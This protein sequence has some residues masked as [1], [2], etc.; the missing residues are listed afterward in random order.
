MA[1]IWCSTS[2][3]RAWNSH[4]INFSLSHRSL[5]RRSPAPSTAGTPR[6]DDGVLDMGGQCPSSD[7]CWFLKPHKLILISTTRSNEL[8]EFQTKVSR[9]PRLVRTDMRVCGYIYI[10]IFIYLSVLMC[11]CLWWDKVRCQVKRD[12][13][14]WCIYTVFTQ[15]ID[16]YTHVNTHI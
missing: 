5:G 4:W 1:F 10:Y 13:V 11:K 6:C 2:I 7:V 9:E 8:F 16:K 12:E 14:R 3:L 15:C